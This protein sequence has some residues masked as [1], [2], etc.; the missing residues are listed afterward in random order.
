MQHAHTN[1]VQTCARAARG[2]RFAFAGPTIF[3]NSH[4]VF[5]QV[6]ELWSERLPCKCFKTFV[7][8]RQKAQTCLQNLQ[9]ACQSPDL[10]HCAPAVTGPVR[11]CM[12]QLEEAI[13]LCDA[14]MAGSSEYDPQAFTS[15]PQLSPASNQG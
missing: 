3:K 7:Q 8:A 13:A 10:I 4:T 6:M 15:N 9:G 12:R 2:A 14:V 1:G 5:L 11:D